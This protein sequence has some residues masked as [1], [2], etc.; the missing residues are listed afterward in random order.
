M[1]NDIT[2]IEALSFTLIVLPVAILWLNNRFLSARS[3]SSQMLLGATLVVALIA[4]MNGNI[5]IL[6]IGILT[7]TLYSLKLVSYFVAS[8]S[9]MRRNEKLPPYKRP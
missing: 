2:F 8:M 6:S 7:F 3:T 9:C 1:M 4:S 5:I